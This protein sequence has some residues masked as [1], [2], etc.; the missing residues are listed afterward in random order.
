MVGVGV[1]TSCA[2]ANPPIKTDAT[3]TQAIF[4]GK[5]YAL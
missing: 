2:D 3:M 1:S 5:S 4:I